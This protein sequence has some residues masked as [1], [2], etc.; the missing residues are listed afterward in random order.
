MI[1]PQNSET[2]PSAFNMAVASLMRLDAIL[3][4]IKETSKQTMNMG[5]A[6]HVKAKLVKD[7]FV[8]ASVLFKDETKMKELWERVKDLKPQ[9]TSGGEGNL[10]KPIFNRDLDLKLDDIIIDTQSELQKTGVF[11]PEYEDE[12]L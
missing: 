3:R 11:M 9:W 8:Q 2:S 4:D 12:G 5:Q 7:F 10:G 6:Q 1:P